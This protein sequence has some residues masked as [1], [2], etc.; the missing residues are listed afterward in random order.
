MV[1]IMYWMY[2]KKKEKKM[3]YKHKNWI[4]EIFIVC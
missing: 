2:C 1:D 4:L 3:C